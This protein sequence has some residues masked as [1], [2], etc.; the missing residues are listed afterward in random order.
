MA[1]RQ[2]MSIPGDLLAAAL[3]GNSFAGT[4]NITRETITSVDQTPDWLK[5]AALGSKAKASLRPDT[6]AVSVQN[7]RLK[8]MTTHGGWLTAGKLGVPTEELKSNGSGSNAMLSAAIPDRRPAGPEGKNKGALTAG[9]VPS[10]W[11]NAFV[12][13]GVEGASI[14]H[15]EEQTIGDAR[16]SVKVVKSVTIGTQWEGMDEEASA[17]PRGSRLP[18]WAKPYTPPSAVHVAADLVSSS[19]EEVS[20]EE[21]PT[22]MGENVS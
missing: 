6:T 10:G 13:S 1:S 8:N 4:T 15:N 20:S 9:V 19:K 7:P 14:F 2:N 11:L 3:S 18:P 21:A 17:P 12:A 5:S 22:V 16:D